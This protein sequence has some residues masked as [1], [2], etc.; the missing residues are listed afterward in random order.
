[1]NYDNLELKYGI[2]GPPCICKFGVILSTKTI[3]SEA[4]DADLFGRV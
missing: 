3:H 2:L 4:E 1:M